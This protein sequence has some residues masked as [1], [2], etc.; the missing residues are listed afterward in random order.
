MEWKG[1]FYELVRAVTRMVLVRPTARWI[2]EGSAVIAAIGLWLHARS[3]DFF[4]DDAFITLRYGQFLWDHGVP[5]YNLGQRVEGYTSPL[6]MVLAAAA[7]A[8]KDPVGF[9]QLCGGLS[10]VLW[11]V[12]LVRVWKL[13]EP[14]A[15]VGG[16]L[17]VWASAM[18][19]PIA[20]WAMG[21][22]ETPLFGALVT[23]SLA[24]AGKLA[25]NPK[26]Y[27]QASFVAVLLA[28]STFAR[29]EGA[30]VAAVVGVALLTVR[31][32]RRQVRAPLLTLGAYALIVGAHVLWRTLYYGYPFPNTYYLKSS[33]EAASL[34]ERGVAYVTLA[35][36]ELGWPLVALVSVGLLLPV[37]RESKDSLLPHLS[38]RRVILWSAKALV[39]LFVPY[40]IRIGGDFLDLY[41][42]FAPILPLAF[43]IVAVMFQ[44]VVRRARL[45]WPVLPAAGL[46]LLGWYGQGQMQLREK[47]LMV[48][49][50]ARIEH[51]IEPLGW[52]RLYALR[53]AALGRWVASLAEP[54]EWM[55]V[56]AAGAMPYYAGISNLDTFGLCDEFV[57]HHG[58]LV[59]SRPGHQRFAPFDYILR[60]RPTF[61]F[62]SD[63]SQDLPLKTLRSLGHFRREG[64]QLVEAQV[65]TDVHGAPEPFYHY[66]YV[67]EDRAKDFEGRPHFRGR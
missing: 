3:Y 29:P 64:Y 59:A 1:F 20:G 36:S 27:G 63:F 22:L 11:I 5:I 44:F 35:A 21:G 28:L 62:V 14:R 48:R 26:G 9:M 16:M 55:A 54:H 58:E 8:T 65:T 30:L 56:G 23:W 40:V 19:C 43:L 15:P 31:F 7:H 52:T 2:L 45:P 33:G 13:L 32:D 46:L 53:W 47:A 18:S 24:E 25:P 37:L 49:E 41:R 39:V 6:W 42:F 50:D 66:L 4:A 67:R 60:R 12:G 61:I 17:V 10:A 51:G 34:A 57:A 38:T